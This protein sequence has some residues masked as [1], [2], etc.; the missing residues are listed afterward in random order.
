MHK[1]VRVA[2]IDDQPIFRQG[3]A[4][5]LAEDKDIKLV[6]QGTHR[7]DVQTIITEH[8]PHILLLEI[9]LRS[10]GVRALKAALPYLTDTKVIVL[11]ASEKSEHVSV[12][13]K[14]GARGYVV[15]SETGSALRQAI[16]AINLGE[17]YVTPQLASN[18]F[19]TMRRRKAAH[20][21]KNE[22][23]TLTKRETEILTC[24]GRGL[25]NKEIAVLLG[26]SEKTVKHYMTNIMNKLQ[27]QNRVQAAL[28]AQQSNVHRAA[29]AG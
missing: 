29:M 1:T 10:D 15:K 16:H 21:I 11:T 4:S 19:K 26:I 22:L 3:L 20:A 23:K 13:S 25:K 7:D 5:V 27:V 12:A 8:Q 28:I 2:L 9:L 14:L 6:A 24:V 18:L 17:T